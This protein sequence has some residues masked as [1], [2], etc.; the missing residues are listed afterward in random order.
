MPARSPVSHSRTTVRR[1]VSA[2]QTNDSSADSA[3]PL[4]KASPSRCTSTVPSARRHSSRPVR[5]FST[6]S[7]FH[8]SIG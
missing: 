8:F 1:A 5:V 2:T 3:T 6:K 7:A 4:A